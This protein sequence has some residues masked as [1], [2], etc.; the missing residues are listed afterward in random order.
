[1]ELKGDILHFTESERTRLQ[2]KLQPLKQQLWQHYLSNK[3][4]FTKLQ[5]DVYTTFA[6]GNSNIM[7]IKQFNIIGNLLS[8]IGIDF[9]DLVQDETK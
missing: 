1:M 2:V 6:Y 7:S 8:E 3:N 9:E 4:S 5:N